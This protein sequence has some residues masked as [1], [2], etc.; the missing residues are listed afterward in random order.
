MTSIQKPPLRGRL[1]ERVGRSSRGWTVA[2]VVALLLAA[3][4]IAIASRREDTRVDPPARVEDEHLDEAGP[5][6]VT[7]TAAAVATARIEVAAVRVGAPA[8]A[9]PGLEVPAQV[10]FD[11]RR[12]AVISPR[13]DGRLEQ[14]TVVEG[15]RVRPG[16]VVALL[17]SKDFLIAQSDLQQ[18]SRRAA[19]LAAGPDAT[20]AQALVQASRRRL[21]LLGVPDMEIDRIAAGGESS[22]HLPLRSPMGGSIMKTHLLSGQAVHAGDP[23][24]TVADL[25]VVDVIAEIPERSL[26][27]VQVWQAAHVSLAA[28]PSTPFLGRVERLR[29]ELNAETRTVRAVI[30]VSN[31]TGQLRPG[32][33]ALVRL[34][35][36][37]SAFPDLRPATDTTGEDPL[38]TIPESAM[39]TDGDR[40]YVFV[41]VLPGTFERR[42][43]RI[44]PLAPPGSSVIPTA[45][46]LV[47]GG[48]KAGEMVVTRGG[49]IL[50]SELAKAG[51]GHGH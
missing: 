30:H 6:R 5:V 3:V 17:N 20:G 37:S 44:A 11:P 4:V 46:V 35:V 24:F 7:L 39:V 51:L 15:D 27:M 41:Q 32:M 47:R 16:Q 31:S 43:V 13:A 49:F 9:S 14:L 26:P 28:F 19:L 12:I 18:T 48:V 10:E 45:F 34:V 40:R 25:S 8:L 23:V 22:L 2:V 33:F 42:E 38:F 50:K 1:G 29:D 21:A 36:P